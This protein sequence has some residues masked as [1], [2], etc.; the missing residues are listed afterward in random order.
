[1]TSDLDLSRIGQV[2][3]V[4]RD[5]E[6]SMEWYSRTLG[7]GPWKVYTNS[8][9]PLDCSYRGEAVSYK[10]RVALGQSGPLVV[11]LLQYLEGDC[12]HRDFLASG[13]IGLEHL[14]IYVADLDAA[15]KPLAEQG[16][17]VLQ[18]A[19]GIGAK[20]DGRYAFLDTEESTGVIM[21]L[22]QVPSERVPPEKVYPE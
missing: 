10:M 21:E 16:V 22:I 4:V 11:E 14:G 15:L 2:G 18:T 5:L 6:E 19:S 7:I 1:V 17:G 12:L 8:A 3:I 9:P 13:R 20:G